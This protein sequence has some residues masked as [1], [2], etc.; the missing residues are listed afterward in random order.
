MRVWHKTIPPKYC[1]EK[2]GMYRGTWLPQM[3]RCWESNDGLSVMSRKI[4][5]D[6]G[7]IEHVTIQIMGLLGGDIPWRIK[8]EVKDELFGETSVAIEVYPSSK[9]LV[10]VCDVYHLWILPEKY[11]LPFRIH[12]NRDPLGNPVQRGYDFNM[13]DC[14]GWVDSAERQ[15]LLSGDG[16]SI[17]A[18]DVLSEINDVVLEAPFTE[19][20][21][22][23]N[24]ED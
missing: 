14:K 23:T 11:K 7:V 5:T 15:A 13:E 2:L 4:R 12:P 18:I 17:T 19:V 22:L 16:R 21:D 20:C 3:D 24:M 9:N 8:Q 10:D 1:H 6:M